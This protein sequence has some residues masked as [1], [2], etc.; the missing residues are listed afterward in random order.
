M[1]DK[2]DLKKVNEYTYETDDTK[3][4][5]PFSS[6]LKSINSFLEKINLKKPELTRIGTHETNSRGYQ[7]TSKDP[8]EATNKKSLKAIL[9]TAFEDLQ[10]KRS[11]NI[12]AKAN[13]N[14]LQVHTV[15]EMQTPD[16][17][18][19]VSRDSIEPPI[20][21]LTAQQRAAQLQQNRQAPNLINNTVIMAEAKSAEIQL[22]DGPSV[23]EIEVYEDPDQNKDMNLDQSQD[24]DVNTIEAVNLDVAANTQRQIIMPKEKPK[25][26]KV[27]EKN[28]DELSM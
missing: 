28:D 4:S 21:P 26:P 7:T 20:I 24:R 19:S 22:E 1:A 15:S 2:D 14:K 8:L 10:K 16:K 5:N 6:A 3:S 17:D 18:Q 25:T 23:G 13:P 11:E 9:R 27:A 12:R